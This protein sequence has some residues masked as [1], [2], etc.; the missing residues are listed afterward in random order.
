MPDQN[1]LYTHTSQPNNSDF[2]VTI[3]APDG[4]TPAPRADDL[5]FISAALVAPNRTFVI[6]M[7]NTA[8][9]DR[10]TTQFKVVTSTDVLVGEAIEFHLYDKPTIATVPISAVDFRLESGNATLSDGMWTNFTSSSFITGTVPVPAGFKLVSIAVVFT[11]GVSPG[12]GTITIDTFRRTLVGG[13]TFNKT[14][15]HSTV[16]VNTGFNWTSS[17]I[18]INF[19]ATGSSVIYSRIQCTSGI[20]FGGIFPKFE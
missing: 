14:A 15:L 5:Y 1:F 9:G 17:I 7:P 3:M 2:T 19:V 16:V 6:D 12:S 13:L 20:S 10:T 4:V 11:R 18:P 8:A